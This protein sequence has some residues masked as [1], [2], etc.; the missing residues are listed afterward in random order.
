MKSALVVTT[1]RELPI[2]GSAFGRTKDSHPIP[3]HM[4]RPPTHATF[5]SSFLIATTLLFPAPPF[6]NPTTPLMAR[7]HT[8]SFHESLRHPQP[9]AQGLSCLVGQPKALAGTQEFALLRQ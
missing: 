7:R 5:T 8:L 3:S 1:S 4:S 9:L 6:A 2:K